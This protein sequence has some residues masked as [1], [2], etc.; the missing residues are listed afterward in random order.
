M[1]SQVCIEPM[2]ENRGYSEKQVQ[3]ITIMMEV[4]ELVALIAVLK[5]A[6]VS[7]LSKK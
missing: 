7:K 4:V 1:V 5:L 2:L 6:G 3:R